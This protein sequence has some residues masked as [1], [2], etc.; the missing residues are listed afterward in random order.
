MLN[1]SKSI[2]TESYLLQ[3]F[4]KQLYDCQVL[5]MSLLSLT[6]AVFHYQ[7]VSRKK[8][9]VHCRVVVGD[10]IRV[11]V[12]RYVIDGLIMLCVGFAVSGVLNAIT[13]INIA[14]NLYLLF[15]FVGYML[16]SAWRVRQYENI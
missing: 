4:L 9:E 3:S 16:I 12:F 5:I 10:T 8:V 7:M 13:D 15:V 11:I 2:S 1:Y 14:D 6:A